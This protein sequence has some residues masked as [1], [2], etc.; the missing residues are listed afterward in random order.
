MNREF[1]DSVLGRMN[2]FLYR[3]AADANYSMMYITD[4][5]TRI[6]GH[7]V[8]AL[9]SNRDY[10]FADLI[11]PDDLEDVDRAVNAGFAARENWNI[12]YRF[13]SQNGTFSWVFECGGG[14]WDDAGH[15]LYSE[16]AVFDIADLRRR[17]DHRQQFLEAAASQTETMIESLSYLKLL[18]INAGILAARAGTAGAGFGVLA[19]EMRGLAE[20]TETAVKELKQRSA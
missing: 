18:S 9:I 19:R 2:G 5:I 16:G 20:Q 12:E 14:V 11:H 15:L 17:T 1:L 10:A 4:G 8:D 6:Y 3:C 13:K 7:P